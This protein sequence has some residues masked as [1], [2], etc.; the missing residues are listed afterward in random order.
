VLLQCSSK[1]KVRLSNMGALGKEDN[2]GLAQSV[3]KKKKKAGTKEK[4]APGQIGRV[5]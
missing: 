5:A 3:K 1:P 2:I 4:E